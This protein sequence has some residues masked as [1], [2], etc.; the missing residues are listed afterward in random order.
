MSISEEVDVTGEQ[1]NQTDWYLVFVVG[2]ATV[3]TLSCWFSANAVQGK[4][5]HY[6]NEELQ[7]LTALTQAGFVL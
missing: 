2:L 3:G 4:L 6:T 1:K 7:T 5:K